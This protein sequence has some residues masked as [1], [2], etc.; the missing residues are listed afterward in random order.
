MLLLAGCNDP[1]TKDSVVKCSP[2]PGES[3]ETGGEETGET[4][5]ETGDEETGG[6]PEMLGAGECIFNVDEGKIGLRYDCFG[7]LHT[8]MDLAI[9]GLFATCEDLLG[10]DGWCSDD[11]FFDD[12]PARVAACC[13]EYDID[14]K[15]V[16]Q[17]FCTYDL[18]QQVCISLAERLE[19]LVQQGL[20]GAYTAKGPENTA[21]RFMAVNAT[22]ILVTPKA[23][24]IWAIDPFMLEYED[25]NHERWTMMMEGSQWR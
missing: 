14:L 16:Y 19:H 25:G 21:N 3:C 4:G 8:S 6:E 12:D 9:T 5:D 17:E 1:V 15:S 23:R 2:I 22:S 18:Y 20:F 7:E 11:F 10:D 13:G 24:G